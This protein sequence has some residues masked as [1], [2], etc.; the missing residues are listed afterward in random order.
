ML[1]VGY[2]RLSKEGNG[3]GIAAQRH[4]VEDYC[5]RRGFELLRIEEDNGASGRS[6]KKRPGLAA[7]IEACQSEGCTAI[8][9]TRVDRLARSSLDFHRIVEQVRGVGATILFTE[10]EG[11]SLDT[12]EGK[13]L[14]GILATFAAFE[15][16]LI[17]ARVKASLEVVRRKGSKSGKPIGNPNFVRVP[18]K[19]EKRIQKMRG[20]G[21]SLRAIA[22]QLESEGVPTMRGGRWQAQTVANIVKRSAPPTD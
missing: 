6:T 1:V 22:D 5:K 4:A 16:D 7:A 21:M 10:Q 20:Q 17:S 9:A 8:V 2:V 3:H 11:F 12:P 15:A 14:V 13:M 18:V 19:L